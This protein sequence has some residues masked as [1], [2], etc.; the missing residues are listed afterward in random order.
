VTVESVAAKVAEAQAR[1]AKVERQVDDLQSVR[2]VQTHLQRAKLSSAYLKTAS[3]DYYAWSLP[4]RASFLGCKVPHLCKS[5]IV[6]NT[7]CTNTGIEDPRNSRYYC[8]IL[9]YNSKLNSEQLMR[10]VRSLIPE[11]ERPGR[12]NFNFQHAPG[13]VSEELTGFLHNGVSPF[14]MK[15]PIPVI[16]SG[17]VAALD[18]PFIWLGGGAETV[19]LRIGVQQLISALSAY[20]ANKN[21]TALRDD[22]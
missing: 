17:E 10:F 11:A 12:K 13:N 7:A 18:P 21:L 22:L 4:Q 2:G 14:G 1:L 19:K 8:V 5:I 9:Q 3:E 6:E 20:V 16:V 15:V